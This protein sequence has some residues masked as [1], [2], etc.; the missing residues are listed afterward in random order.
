MS[1]RGG[2]R[3]A[4]V[5]L[6][7]VAL[8]IGLLPRPVGAAEV[9]PFT[10]PRAGTPVAAVGDSLLGQLESEGPTHPRSLR[11]FTR[12]LQDEGWRASVRPRNAWRV[13]RVRL[14]ADAARAR[15]AEVVVVSAGSG[16]VRWVREQDDPVAARQ[17]SRRAAA[18]LLAS[19]E[20][21][22]VVWPTVPL[23]GGAG[24]RRTAAGLNAVLRS[25]AGPGVRVPEWAAAATEHPGWF[26]G[27]RVHLSRSGE[28]AFQRVLL[29]A[30][31]RCVREV[32]SV[33]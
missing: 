10:G 24:E 14:L 7:A 22:C 16:D 28:A 15:G 2:G 26:I 19:L 9:P 23:T 18:R 13:A 11:A 32:A 20:E 4:A 30:V 27:D 5:L 25:A 21:V 33:D 31:R 12:S 8:G 6:G 17:A 3:L 29:T 1:P